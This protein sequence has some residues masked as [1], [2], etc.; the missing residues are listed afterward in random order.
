M[1]SNTYTTVVKAY[2]EVVTQTLTPNSTWNPTG[3][4]PHGYQNTLIS[5]CW[6]P[7][8]GEFEQPR[9]FING[10]EHKFSLYDSLRPSQYTVEGNS[11]YH[12]FKTSTHE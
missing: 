7:A 2:T 8:I 11:Y 1:E 9:L 10:V 4:C 3:S 12:T 5:K 6:R